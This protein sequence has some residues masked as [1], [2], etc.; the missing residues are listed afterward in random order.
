MTVAIGDVIIPAQKEEILAQ[1]EAQA[2]KVE[3]SYQRGNL[4][5]AERNADLVRI[6][7]QATKEIE[8]VIPD[9]YPT[10]NP[11]GIA[12]QGRRRR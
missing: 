11:I 4:S 2:E 9:A 8:Q 7:E 6:W 12:G 5:H 1:H 10:D 3:K